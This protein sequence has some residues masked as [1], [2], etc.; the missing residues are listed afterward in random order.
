MLELKARS[1]VS[2]TAEVMKVAIVVA[3][4]VKEG[5]ACEDELR[6]VLLR[7]ES[8]SAVSRSSNDRQSGPELTA[9]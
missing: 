2:R 5:Y 4:G 3:G 7:C 6:K 1:A 9:G 8:R